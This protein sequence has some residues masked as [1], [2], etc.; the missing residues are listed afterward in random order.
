MLFDLNSPHINHYT[1]ILASNRFTSGITKPTRIKLS[2]TS[3]DHTIT[4][5]QGTIIKPGVLQY[6]VSDHLSIFC[7]ASSVK[8]RNSYKKSANN[9]CNIKNVH[10]DAVLDDLRNTPTLIVQIF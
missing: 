1:Q 2:Q 8:P 7:I 4:N 6:S 5:V 3:I 10:G 9:Y